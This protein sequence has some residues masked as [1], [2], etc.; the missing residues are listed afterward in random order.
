MSWIPE[1]AEADEQLVEVSRNVVEVVCS[2]PAGRSLREMTEDLLSKR[3][4]PGMRHI[5]TS[6]AGLVKSGLGRIGIGSGSPVDYEII[7]V[8][9]LGGVSAG[10]LADVRATVDSSGVNA[11]R[12]VLVGGSTMIVDPNDTLES[13]FS[14]L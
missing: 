11:G 2:L 13:V 9:V 5:G 10:E 14:E 1:G 8:F 7:V 3:D 6:I 4:V 12:M